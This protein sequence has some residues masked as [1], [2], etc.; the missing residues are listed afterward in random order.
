MQED[1]GFDDPRLS[2]VVG[3]WKKTISGK[4]G[5]CPC[6]NRFGKIYGRQ[7]N[8]TMARSLIWL[9]KQGGWV[10]VPNN[11]PKWVVRTNQLPTLRWWGLVERFNDVSPKLYFR[12]IE[13]TVKK[14]SGTW[15]VTPLGEAFA[16]NDVQIAKKVYT[17][18]NAEEIWFSPE[19]V[20]IT[21]CFKVKFDYT[22]MMR[23]EFNDESP[24]EREQSGIRF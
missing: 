23:E 24:R 13:E 20:Y 5:R 8:K 4:G 2:Q 6:C 9:Y 10:D 1:F 16:E 22:E 3:E 18:N 21:S 19:M 17:Y 14:H 12:H 11:G 15:R 7:I